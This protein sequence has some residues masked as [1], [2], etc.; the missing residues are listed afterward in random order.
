MMIA[1]GVFMETI[2]RVCASSDGTGF[3]IF[4]VLLILTVFI[5]VNVA[6]YLWVKKRGWPHLTREGEFNTISIIYCMDKLGAFFV[7]CFKKLGELIRG[8]LGR[9]EKTEI[10]L[11]EVW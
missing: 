11:I 5:L 4:I 7:W 10:K 2:M 1:L 6:V 3:I 9:G 8:L